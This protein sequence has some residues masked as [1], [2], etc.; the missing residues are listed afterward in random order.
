MMRF[1]LPAAL[2]VA[3]LTGFAQGTFWTGNDLLTRCGDSTMPG[4]LVCLTYLQGVADTMIVAQ[5]PKGGIMGWRACIPAGVQASQLRDVATR[6]LREHPEQRHSPAPS[7]VAMSL[8]QAFP[9]LP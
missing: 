3:P 1:L 4:T 2:A 7:L 6:F 8:A 9:C 5:T